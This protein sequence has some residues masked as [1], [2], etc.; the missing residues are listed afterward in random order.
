MRIKKRMYDLKAAKAAAKKPEFIFSKNWLIHRVLREALEAAVRVYAG[1]KLVDIGCGEKPY[2]EM[3]L[4]YLESYVGIDHEGTIHDTS[5]MDREGSAYQLPARDE[6]FDTVLCTEVLEHLEEP[7]E[8]V[9]EAARVL[10]PGGYAIYT[11]PLFWHLHEEPRDYFRFTRHGLRYLFEKN[12]FEIVEIQAISSF[13]VTFG[14]ELVYY[15]WRFRRGG[16]WNPL[17]WLIPVLGTMIQGVAWCLNSLDYP[18]EFATEYLLVA[19]KPGNAAKRA[20]A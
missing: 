2:L 20:E 16:R 8:A 4:P 9:R 17:W 18:A 7:G 6:E 10:A 1:G 15:L 12:G 3:L 13:W 5:Y 14:Q 19:H 11:V